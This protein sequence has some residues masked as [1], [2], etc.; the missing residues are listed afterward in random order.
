MPEGLY[1]V[2]SGRLVG[3]AE[4]VPRELVGFAQTDGGAWRTFEW[5]HPYP[6]ETYAVTLNV[7]PHCR[8]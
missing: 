7:A 6:V 2:S 8:R 4:G 3:V 5:R 1:G